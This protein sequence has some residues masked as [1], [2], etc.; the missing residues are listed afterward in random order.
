MYH[1]NMNFWV[2]REFKSYECKGVEEGY[3]VVLWV[4]YGRRLGETDD[5]AK[6]VHST[7]CI[8]CGI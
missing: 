8:S 6:L 1:E 2:D 5:G 3:E 4:F 7:G